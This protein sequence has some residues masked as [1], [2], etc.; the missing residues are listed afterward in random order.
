[1]DELVKQVL[2]NESRRVTIARLQVRPPRGRTQKGFPR[3]RRAKQ[4]PWDRP[5]QMKL[6]LCD[7]VKKYLRESGRIGR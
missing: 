1:M 5:C 4:M 3:Q 2:E 7:S 6:F